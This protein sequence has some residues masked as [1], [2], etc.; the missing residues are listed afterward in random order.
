MGRRLK[1]KVLEGSYYVLFGR[2][3][4]IMSRLSKIPILIPSGVDVKVVDQTVTIKGPKGVMVYELPDGIVLKFEP[5]KV[6][7][8]RDGKIEISKAAH[9]LY[10]ALLGIKIVG[11]SKGFEK[12]LVLIGTGYRVVK[13]GNILD[14]VTGT[15][16][17]N[18]LPVPEGITVLIEGK[19]TLITVSG[20]DKQAVGQF[21]ATIYAYLPPEPFK[22]KGFRYKG[23]KVRKKAGKAG[24]AKR[25]AG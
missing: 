7:V 2:A 1:K 17:L 10:R 9:G 18:P 8:E 19:G 21:A 23:Q 15:S 4:L 12:E 3:R 14:L 25:A 24:K 20:I 11:V 13:E 22:G 6:V 5:G 16:H